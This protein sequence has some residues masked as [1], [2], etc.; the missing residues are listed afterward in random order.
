[1][2]RLFGSLGPGDFCY[3]TPPIEMRFVYD[4][5]PLKADGE[6]IRLREG[7]Y[8]FSPGGEA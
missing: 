1:M 8:S 5:T 3:Q 6:D 2:L 7:G 4:Y